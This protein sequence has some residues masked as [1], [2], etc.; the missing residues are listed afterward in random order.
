[1]GPQAL[2]NT[3]R[4]AGI[5]LVLGLALSGGAEAQV[6]TAAVRRAAARAVA[7]YDSTLRAFAPFPAGPDEGLPCDEVVGRF[8]LIYG[9]GRD[10]PVP[11]EPREVT[12][13][14]A[15]AV[16]RLS[17]LI[18]LLPHD[19]LVAGPLVRLLVDAGETRQAVRAA[20]EFTRA[21]TAD[22]WSYLLL[23]YALHAD[24]RPGASERAYLAA[25]R[26]MS[27][28]ERRRATDVRV[29]LAPDE[30]TVYD[31]LD[32]R[33]RTIYVSELWRAADP[34]YLVPGNESRNE[35]LGRY[36]L[37]RMMAA[38]RPLAGSPAW[39]DDLAELTRRF[40]LPVAAAPPLCETAGGPPR[41][42]T[43]TVP[44]EGRLLERGGY[45]SPDARTWVPPEFSRSPLPP[46]ALPG[47]SEWFYGAVP[48]T[49]ASAPA[50]LGGMAPLDHQIA[51]F[52]AGDAQL[53]RADVDFDLA[54]DAPPGAPVEFGLFVLDS[55]LQ[56]VAQ[57]RDTALARGTVAH[58]SMEALMP[59][60][61]F[62]YSVEA[63]EI[64]TWQAAR[65]R[66]VLPGL[67]T[68]T[69][70]VSGLLIVP[71]G[72]ADAGRESPRFRPLGSLVLAR[73]RPFGLHVEV[74]GPDRSEK[75]ALR[76]RLELRPDGM[77]GDTDAQPLVRDGRTSIG[78]EGVVG[79]EV[80]PLG[81]AAGPRRLVLTLTDEASGRSATVER[82][83]VFR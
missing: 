18:G 69:L 47:S 83:V 10:R 19:S 50:T 46:P 62:A 9:L 16:A 29:L 30:R 39:G 32:D 35:D 8:C 76:W 5:A 74:A 36:V 45:Y 21:D 7:V 56:V 64:G 49:S 34:L 25:L 70:S 78:A 37:N 53:L 68:G 66:H 75:I 33:G 3:G 48:R 13:A 1:M 79:V 42:V 43:P 58:G 59:E 44:C 54:D 60:G 24:L 28:G 11:P 80:E 82:R 27:P 51:R 41:P 26:R 71:P 72:T 40:G 52:Q 55:A 14:R 22:A 6:D 67:P 31:D 63:R 2:R 15:D 17:P 81:V 12:V 57:R 20:V 65:A 77:E 73:D 4:G 61:A 23:G 38:S